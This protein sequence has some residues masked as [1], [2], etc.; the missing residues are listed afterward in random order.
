M[1]RSATNARPLTA[2]GQARSSKSVPRE[3]FPHAATSV[4]TASR[5]RED[6]VEGVTLE[7]QPYRRRLR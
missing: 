4:R 3:T 5:V 7:R 2:G 6:P 1:T